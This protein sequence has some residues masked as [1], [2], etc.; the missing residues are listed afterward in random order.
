MIYAEANSLVQHRLPFGRVGSHQ[1]FSSPLLFSM[2]CS[3]CFLTPP[4]LSEY[5]TKPHTEPETISGEMLVIPIE[6]GY[7]N[8]RMVT[9]AWKKAWR[10]K[11]KRQVKVQKVS[12]YILS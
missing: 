10:R 12:F 5:T 4:S 11:K 9:D 8:N 7:G 2:P 3:F 1:L 6:K